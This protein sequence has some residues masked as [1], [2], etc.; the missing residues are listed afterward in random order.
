[1]SWTGKLIAPISSALASNKQWLRVEEARGGGWYCLSGMKSDPAVNWH[2][3]DEEGT[4]EALNAMQDKR[5][6]A[7]ATACARWISAGYTVQLLAWR[8]GSRAIFKLQH[9]HVSSYAKIF[10]K[11][12]QTIERWEHLADQSPLLPLQT[13]TV[14]DW[15][16]Q[17]KVLVIES[18]VG[19]SL[20]Q[21][22]GNGIWLPQHLEALQDVI[23][24]LAHSTASEN[25]PEHTVDDE[26]SILRTRS[27]VFH[28]ILKTPHPKAK[29][30]VERT[31]QGL[32]DLADVELTL[33]HRD[34]HDKQVITSTRVN[35]LIDLDLLA[36][37]DP[38]LDP[39]NIIAHC[40]LRALQGMPVPWQKVASTLAAD[41]RERNVPG[42]HLKAW[43]AATM[44]RLAL[45]YCRRARFDGFIHNLLISLNAL[46][47]DRGEWE[48]L[49]E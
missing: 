38:A 44:C 1:M 42:V 43:T 11:D 14:L 8:V 16:P 46:L 37:S 12:R 30:L 5:L 49:F 27:E 17:E 2:H 15:N 31:I 41:A 29:E 45:I 7:M 3:L 40:R 35:S 22:W 20:H 23:S 33:S 39:G 26:I 9:K 25:L 19:S 47:E 10:R 36:R 6:P 21:Q 28:R 4:L 24:W 34:L 48:G 18:Q 13:P 32:Q